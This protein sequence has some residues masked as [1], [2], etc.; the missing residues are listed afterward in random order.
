MEGVG[1]RR[2]IFL[3]TLIF[4]G[5]AQFCRA[6]SGN[7]EDAFVGYSEHPLKKTAFP[8]AQQGSEYLMFSTIYGEIKVE[9][10]SIASPKAA[11]YIKS[12]VTRGLTDGCSFYRAEP[13]GPTFDEGHDLVRP[14]YALVQGGLYSCGRQETKNLPVET[15]LKNT[16]GAVSLIT[17][18]SEFFFNLEA[19]PEWDGSFSVFGR[20]AGTE[21][22]NT[23]RRLVKSP[24]RQETHSS[25]TILRMLISPVPFKARLV[26]SSLDNSEVK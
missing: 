25:G 18:T 19:H 20:V 5:I 10:A 7:R 6:G 9:L 4:L 15:A 17:G 8:G 16:K 3:L 14:G 11:E 22:W 1:R 26:P 24:T 13:A 12:L 2:E 23:L 21:S